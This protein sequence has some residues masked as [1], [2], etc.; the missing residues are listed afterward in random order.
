V[1]CTP[2]CGRDI[3][4]RRVSKRVEPMEESRMQVIV[5]RKELKTDRTGNAYSLL[6]F[7]LLILPSYAFGTV[8]LMTSSVLL[9]R[10]S[11]AFVEGHWNS[12]F[13][14]LAMPSRYHCG[15]GVSLTCRTRTSDP[16]QPLGPL[17]YSPSRHRCCRGRYSLDQRGWWY[18]RKRRCR[19]WWGWLA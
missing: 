1:V 18:S 16:L 11:G 9:P 10:Q 12:L 3:K 4:K 15:M 7:A 2:S 14:S 6:H 5:R 8:I 19:R 13:T 17:R